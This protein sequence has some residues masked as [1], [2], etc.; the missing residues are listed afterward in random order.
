VAYFVLT[1]CGELVTATLNRTTG[2]HMLTA[3]RVLTSVLVMSATALAAG[4]KET[5][6]S[7]GLSVVLTH[8][9][10]VTRDGKEAL[11]AADAAKPGEVIEY[12][13]AYQ[14]KGS[15]PLRRV[16]ATLPVPVGTEVLPNSVRPS[17]A[18]ASLD[19]I[20]FQPV[21]LKRKVKQ[22]DGKEVEQLVPFAEY[23]FLRWSV[24]TLEPGKELVYMAK[25][26]TVGK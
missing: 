10:V 14:N 11:V 5:D 24:G 1:G 22:A 4:Q 9:K 25:L 13:A 21:P 26:K 23:R 15:A 17:N 12:Q 18:T 19:G 2:E 20:T 16:E 6:S 7:T 3:L 8:Q